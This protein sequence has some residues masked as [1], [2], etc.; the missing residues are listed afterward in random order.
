LIVEAVGPMVTIQDRGRPG[1]AR[2]GVPPSGPLDAELHEAAIAAASGVVDDAS[3]ASAALEIPLGGARLRAV[4]A[5]AWSLDGAPPTWL[6]DGAHLDVAPSRRAVRYLAVRGGFDVPRVLG[7]RA[8]LPVARLGGLDGRP[9]RA[10]DRIEIGDA[11]EAPRIKRA[12]PEPD[13]APLPILEL[14]DADPALFG[15]MLSGHFVIDPRSDRIGTRL[16]AEHPLP[17]AKPLP[18]S[19]PLVPGA[20]QVPPDGLP[21]VIGP[22][23]PTT[24]GYPLVAILGRAARASLARRRPGASVRFEPLSHRQVP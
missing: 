17:T 23:G 1:F 3:P 10:G 9:L 6:L 22:D 19:R 16:R 5:V 7:A 14:D 20:I 8:T 12:V 2:Y 24:G 18:F 4:G 13:D 21:I 15:A 11:A